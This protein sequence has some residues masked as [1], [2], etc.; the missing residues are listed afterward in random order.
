MNVFAHHGQAQPR[1]QIAPK[2][3]ELIESTKQKQQTKPN[4]I[5]LV[6]KSH[7]YKMK[8]DRKRI[9]LTRN[10][11]PSKLYP[12]RPRIASSASRASSNCNIKGVKNL[13]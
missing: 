1:N 5:S 11:H 7:I 9:I 4:S 13:H 2:Q 6:E 12:S 10:L 3:M 8:I